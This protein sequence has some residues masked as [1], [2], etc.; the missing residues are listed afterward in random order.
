MI[1]FVLETHVIRKVPTTTVANMTSFN[2]TFSP[3]LSTSWEFVYPLREGLSVHFV[4]VCLSTSWDFACPVRESLPLNFVCP[5]REG[6]PVNF[7]RVCRTSWNFKMG[8]PD[9]ADITAISSSWEF[10]AGIDTL[11]LDKS[12]IT[13]QSQSSKASARFWS[14]LVFNTQARIKSC[15][16]QPCTHGTLTCYCFSAG[17]PST[18][19]AQP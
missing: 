1:Y 18:T 6:L 4:R 12:N 14:I 17:L 16:D 5:L 19:L 2:S 11:K 13:K 7:V 8:T 3:E 10:A 9:M 15:M